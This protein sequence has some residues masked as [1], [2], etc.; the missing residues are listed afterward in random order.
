[1]IISKII[2]EYKNF[3][4]S[5]DIA[6]QLHSLYNFTNGNG[7]SIG[8]LNSDK[9]SFYLY[10]YNSSGLALLLFPINLIIKNT[11]VSAFILNIFNVLAFALWLSKMNGLLKVDG[12]LE[13][14]IIIFFIFIVSPFV[15]HWPS[16]SLAMTMCLW[17]VY[18][19]LKNSISR[20]NVDF[21]TSVFFM[22]LAYLIK[23]SF[24]PFLAFP[25]LFF[26]FMHGGLRKEKLLPLAKALFVTA[27][28]GILFFGINYYFVGQRTEDAIFTGKIYL[29]NLLKTDGFLFHLG[30]YEYFIQNIFTNNFNINFQF[31]FLSR[32]VTVTII[33]ILLYNIIKKSTRNHES[34]SLRLIMTSTFLAIALIFT[35]LG[36]LS[37]INPS[38]LIDNQLWTFVENT[39][40]YSPVI[41][42]GYLFV[43][44]YLFKNVNHR[45]FYTIFLTILFIN[46]LSFRSLILVGNFGNDFS[47]YRTL[48]SRYEQ[49]H[50]LSQPDKVIYYT[51]SVKNTPEYFTLLASG[52]ILKYYSSDEKIP[53]RKNLKSYI[54]L[55]NSKT[56]VELK[57][58]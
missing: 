54:L 30:N 53:P 34:N 31:I 37:L 8:I 36:L 7:I 9:I 28:F 18:F 6:H 5:P 19:T 23:Y 2:L 38:I 58:Y 4:L 32:I 27:C 55:F 50:I 48:Q 15:Y 51:D 57:H 22:S 16:D 39:R 17:G 1:M 56:G 13:K 40:Y 49:Q 46:F 3:S 10:N 25:I 35:F 24:F 29:Q 26:L 45:I 42:L 41:I 52:M 11:I 12:Y 47:K 14:L 44:L 20:K 33:F 21:I 43:L